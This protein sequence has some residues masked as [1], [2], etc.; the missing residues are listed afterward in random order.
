VHL[1]ADIAK[2]LAHTCYD[3]PVKY[4]CWNAGSTGGRQGFLEA[5]RFRQDFDGVIAGAPVLDF[6]SKND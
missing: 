2:R 6:G 3:Q 4:A 5:Q 1:T